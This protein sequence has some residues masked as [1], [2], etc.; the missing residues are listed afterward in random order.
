MGSKYFSQTT[1][2]RFSGTMKNPA[3]N[4]G[5][6]KFTPPGGADVISD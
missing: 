6:F 2:P 3:V 5:V 1:F 4:P